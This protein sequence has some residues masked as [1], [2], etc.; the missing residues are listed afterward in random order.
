VGAGSLARRP[1]T[2][3]ASLPISGP[4]KGSSMFAVLAAV[5][6]CA[7]VLLVEGS[8]VYYRHPLAPA[9]LRDNRSLQVTISTAFSM[10]FIAA[11]FML[12]QFLVDRAGQALSGGEA[13]TIL[14]VLGFG[15][16]L[17]RWIRKI[18]RSLDE[19]AAVRPAS[20]VIEKASLARPGEKSRVFGKESGGGKAA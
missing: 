16:V 11:L 20:I 4:F 15:F 2:E 13:A 17:W 1:E 6:G 7:T 8:L 5:V 9:W 19:G 12:G 10:G 3:D 14:G 18:G